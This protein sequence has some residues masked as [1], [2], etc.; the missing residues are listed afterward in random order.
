VRN[1]VSHCR[2]RPDTPKWEGFVGKVGRW[3]GFV[4]KVGGVKE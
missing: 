3:E 1:D 4:E 2:A